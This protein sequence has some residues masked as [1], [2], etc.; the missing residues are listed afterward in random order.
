M[1]IGARFKDGKL[2]LNNLQIERELKRE[3]NKSSLDGLMFTVK[4]E[5]LREP[6]TFSQ[7]RYF[8][9][10]G[11][12]GRII[13]A[14]RDAGYDV[15]IGKER[16]KDWL[17]FQIKTNPSIDFTKMTENV[18][19]GEVRLELRSFAD[20]SK[21][22]LSQIIDWTIRT[23]QEYFGIEIETVDEY[24]RKLKARRNNKT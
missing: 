22:E 21:E 2:I 24:K 15:P 3:L 18:L 4:I 10:D 1:K 11:V 14:Y 19:T 12:F 7:L 17:K 23:H 5:K 16:A 13:S 20:A 9:S 8:H 6:K